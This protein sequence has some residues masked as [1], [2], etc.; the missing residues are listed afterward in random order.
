MGETRQT[1]TIT[2]IVEIDRQAINEFGGLFLDADDNL[3]NPR[4]LE[5]ILEAVWGSMFGVEIYPTIIDKAAAI[6]WAIIAKHV[7]HDGN[8][9]TGIL[10]CQIFLE[11]NGYNMQIALDAPDE[12]A[13]AISEGIAKQQIDLPKFTSWVERRTKKL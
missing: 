6:G 9:R 10:A 11:L 13:I 5:Y 12:E 2:D 1:L 8:K 7:F 3:V 4:S